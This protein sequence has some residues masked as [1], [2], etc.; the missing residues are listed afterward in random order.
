WDSLSQYFVVIILY[1]DY[2]HKAKKQRLLNRCFFAL[3]R[4]TFVPNA[5]SILSYFFLNFWGR[6]GADSFFFLNLNEFI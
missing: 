4:E 3:V 1:Q 2:L 5:F 6:F